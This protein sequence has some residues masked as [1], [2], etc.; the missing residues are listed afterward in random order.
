MTE[1]DWSSVTV[2]DVAYI[3]SGDIP[4]PRIRLKK[5]AIYNPKANCLRIW[6]NDTPIYENNNGTICRD[7]DALADCLL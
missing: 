2:E 5:E 3:F 4:G 7:R 1:W 6:E